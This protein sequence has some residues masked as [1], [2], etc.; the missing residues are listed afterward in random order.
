MA[1]SVTDWAHW[2]HRVTQAFEFCSNLSLYTASYT[3]FQT[4]YKHED[5]VKIIWRIAIIFHPNVL[6]FIPRRSIRKV[7]FCAMCIVFMR[8]RSVHPT[9]SQSSRN[10]Q[11]KSML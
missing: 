7:F 11:H 4:P 9:Q 5:C 1:D 10:F 8:T 2:R 6:L 3:A